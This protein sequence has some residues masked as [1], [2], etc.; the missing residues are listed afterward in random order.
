MKDIFDFNH[1]DS[2]MNKE[3]LSEIK[4]LFKFYHKQLR[5]HRKVYKLFKRIN[6][7]I[8]MSSTSL[9][10]IGTIVG[11]ITLNPIAHKHFLK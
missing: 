8:D 1:L 6:L 4:A 5:C 2:N 9:V 3:K 11:G 10:V 7:L